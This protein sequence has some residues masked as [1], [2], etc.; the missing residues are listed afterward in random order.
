MITKGDSCAFPVPETKDNVV[1]WGLSIREYF[2]GGAM[3]GLVGTLAGIDIGRMV[4]EVCK[5]GE[6]ETELKRG[7][8]R[9]SAIAVYFADALIAEL[10][11]PVKETP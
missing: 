3:Q 2:A 9:L 1:E 5:P 10:N 8:E 7:T 4:E 6:G 11:K